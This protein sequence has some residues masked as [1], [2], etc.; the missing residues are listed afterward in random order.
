MKTYTNLSNAQ[1]IELAI[2][3]GEGHLADNGALVVKTGK[4]TGR[5]PLDRFIVD[6]PS[7]S[8]EI[9]RAHV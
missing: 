2:Q 3:R 7:T 6:E 9:G 5:S 1:L 8:A 4:R